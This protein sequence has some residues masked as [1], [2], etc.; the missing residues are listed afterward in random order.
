MKFPI[1]SISNL[2]VEYSHSRIGSKMRLDRDR[3][4]TRDGG[5]THAGQNHVWQQEWTGLRKLGAGK[6][7]PQ[8]PWEWLAHESPARREHAL[9]GSPTLQL[10][11]CDKFWCKIY[12]QWR[13]MS[14]IQDIAHWHSA[15]PV[16]LLFC[17][18]IISRLDFWLRFLGHGWLPQPLPRDLV[19]IYSIDSYYVVTCKSTRGPTFSPVG[20]ERFP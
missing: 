18:R 4:V 2:N 10:L 20:T 9:D 16:T 5:S 13:N 14:D 19:C 11:L 17:L 15:P 7:L 6:E 3:I 12:A 1:I 8:W